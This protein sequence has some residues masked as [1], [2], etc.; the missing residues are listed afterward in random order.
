MLLRVNDEPYLQRCVNDVSYRIMVFCAGDNIGVQ[1]VAFPQQS[2]IKINGG[3][4][5]ANLRGLK[6]KP[7]S[8]RPVDITNALRLKQSNYPNKVELTYALTQKVCHV[9]VHC[10]RIFV[11]Q[12]QKFYV[13][14][15]LCKINTVDDLARR[16][17]TRQRIPKDSVIAESTFTLGRR[18][19][20]Y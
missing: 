10:L 6:N 7:G 15:Y 3:D 5:K 14:V 11:D 2:E 4:F 8:T 17:E 18:P 19:A 20:L 1:H 12:I 9:H 16:L 13:V